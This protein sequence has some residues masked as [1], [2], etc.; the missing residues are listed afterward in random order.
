MILRELYTTCVRPTVEFASVVWAG[1]SKLDCA[2]L[3]RVNRRAARIIAGPTRRN[4]LASDLVLARAGL[5]PLVKRR[6]LAL[7]LFA[8]KVSTRLHLLPQYITTTL[9]H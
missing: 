7:C 9:S 2:R 3:E 8:H 5:E 4:A 6:P 1:M